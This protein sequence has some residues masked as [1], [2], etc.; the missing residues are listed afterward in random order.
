M[1]S[2]TSRIDYIDVVKFLG[3][4]AIYLGHLANSAGIL[5]PFV[6]KYHVPLFFFISGFTVN[7]EKKRNFPQYL[8]S[9]IKTLIIPWAFFALFS[10]LIRGLYENFQFDI[11]AELIKII[12]GC[13]RNQYFAG[14]LWFLTCLFVINLIYYLVNRMPFPSKI[15]VFFIFLSI[16]L[17]TENYI[18]T[19]PKWPWNID[20]AMIYSFNYCLGALSFPYIHKIITSDRP[21]YH[22]IRLFIGLASVTLSILI[23]LNKL[24]HL[25]YFLSFV[26]NLPILKYLVSQIEILILI[27]ANL[28]IAVCLRKVKSL[29]LIGCDVLFLCG[30]E[31]IVKLCTTFIAVMFNLNVCLPNPLTA[32]LFTALVIYIAYKYLIPVEKWIIIQLQDGYDKKMCQIVHQ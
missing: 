10:L 8:S 4:F 20:S 26:N 31:Y 17:I 3:V 28:S 15:I 13:I 22:F 16:L 19:E 1:N 18:F 32:V 6:F 2:S 21:K 9:K 23:L 27:I 5:Y 29:Q 7:L 25:L 12:Y 14:G 11:S 30:S 24:P